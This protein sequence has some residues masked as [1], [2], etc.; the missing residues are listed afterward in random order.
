MENDMKKKSLLLAVILN[1]V[2]IGSGHMYLGLWFKGILLLI[3]A[4][5][6]GI[7]SAGMFALFPM[8]IGVVDVVKCT[9]KINEGVPLENLKNKWLKY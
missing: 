6:V 2:I 3:V 5:V 7:F 8:F 9:N 4:I 1:I